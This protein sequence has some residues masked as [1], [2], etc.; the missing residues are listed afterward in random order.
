MASHPGAA[1]AFGGTAGAPPD[2]AAAAAVLK[3]KLQPFALQHPLNQHP[4]SLQQKLNPPNLSQHRK[5]PRK[6]QNQMATCLKII[7]PLKLNCCVCP[8]TST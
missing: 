4:Q 2:E 6:V 3:Q 8:K 1:A 7:C 5:R